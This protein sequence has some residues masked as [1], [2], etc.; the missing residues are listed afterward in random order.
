[1]PAVFVFSPNFQR[2][3]GLIRPFRIRMRR[4][5]PFEPVSL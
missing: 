4:D 1:M 2:R 5:L 3:S